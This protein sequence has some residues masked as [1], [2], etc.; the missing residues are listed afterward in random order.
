MENNIA[1]HPVEK[2]KE[3]KNEIEIKKWSKITHPIYGDG[4]VLNV[5]EHK[6]KR[7]A[8]VKFEQVGNKLILIDYTNIRVNKP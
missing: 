5:Y 8:Y 7:K 2:I 4:V 3:N 6:G 1:E